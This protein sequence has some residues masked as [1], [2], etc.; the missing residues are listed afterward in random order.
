[1]NK[2]PLISRL[3]TFFLVLGVG[4]L[5]LFITSDLA[6]TPDFDLLFIAILLIGVGWLFQRRKPP[7]PASGRFSMLRRIRGGQQEPVENPDQDD[8]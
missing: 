3:G 4:V 8:T 7:K 1:M 6:Q 5:I 2:D